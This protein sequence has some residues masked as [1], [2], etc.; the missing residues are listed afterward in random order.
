MIGLLRRFR[1]SFGQRSSVQK[2][3]LELNNGPDQEMDVQVEPIPD[4]RVVDA[5]ASKSLVFETV[6][7]LP[8]LQVDISR[9]AS[10]DCLIVTIWD[11]SSRLGDFEFEDD[12][13]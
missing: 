2:V 5:G 3:K 10:G 7:E 8:S 6:S 13:R 12:T 1:E 11:N 9:N 4:G